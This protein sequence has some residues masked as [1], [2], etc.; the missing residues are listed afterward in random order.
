VLT[1]WD[2]IKAAERMQAYIEEHLGAKITMAALAR[3]A[4]YS[5]WHAARVFKEVTGKSPF[6]YVRLRRLSSAAERL[7]G[8]SCKV[9]D[10]AF[11]FV[12]DTPTRA[13]RGPS[14]GSSAC[15]HATSARPGVDRGAVHAPAAP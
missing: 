13:S 4:R 15:L 6:E 12:F 14:P 1:Q 11:D 9:I 10:V 5:Q 8:T 3:A 2:K 7:R